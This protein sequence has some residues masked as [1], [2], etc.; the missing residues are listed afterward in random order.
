MINNKIK[1]LKEASK[2]IAKELTRLLRQHVKSVPEI[3]SDHLKK[4]VDS[5]TSFIFLATDSENRTIG[6][7]TLI[8]APKLEGLHKAIIEDLVVDTAHRGQG[9]GKALMKTAVDKANSL[10]ISSV[11]LTCRSERVAA[12][13]LYK[14]LGFKLVDTNNYRYELK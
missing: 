9:I 2:Q 7:V 3:T 11:S 4:I 6:M 10:N 1:Q 12:N 8:C 5:K 14:C 13:A